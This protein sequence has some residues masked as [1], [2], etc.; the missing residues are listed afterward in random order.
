[1]TQWIINIIIMFLCKVLKTLLFY[2]QFKKK[3]RNDLVWKEV[4]TLIEWL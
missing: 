4:G 2:E 3:I 1:M